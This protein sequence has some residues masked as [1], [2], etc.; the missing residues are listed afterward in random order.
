MTT[1]NA[2]IYKVKAGTFEGPMDVLLR[3]IEERKLFINEI[4]L[5]AIAD[6]YIGY[7]RALSEF[8]AND[9]T[10][11]ILVA[12]TLVLIKSK[13]LLPNLSLTEEES[14][15]IVDLERRLRLYQRIKDAGIPIK[16]AFGKAIIFARSEAFDMGPVFSPDELITKENMLAAMHS[17]I[18]AAPKKE[19]LPEVT[20]KKVIN[21]EE[22]IASLAERIQEGLRMSFS[23]FAGR[24]KGTPPTKE[25]KVYV[26]VSFLAM[27]ELVREGLINAIQDNRFED[28]TLEKQREL[29]IISIPNA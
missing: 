25:E 1:E 5:A 15:Q 4:S 3:L 20:I 17:I 18:A 8:R 14:G 11:F 13:S 9:V 27:L 21:I 12:A 6:D 29:E 7:V 22:M 26:I 24:T 2:T 23:D 10:G 28:I 19:A 16:E